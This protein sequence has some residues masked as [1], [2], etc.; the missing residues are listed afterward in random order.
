MFKKA[1]FVILA[2]LGI[3]GSGL[4]FGGQ[5][6]TK[7]INIVVCMAPNICQ[8]QCDGTND[9]VEIKNAINEAAEKGGDTVNIQDGVYNISSNLNVLA[10][11][12]TIKGD[13]ASTTILRANGNFKVLSFG[14]GSG[15][16]VYSNYKVMDLTIDMNFINS[17]QSYGLVFS[18]AQNVIVER[19]NVINA[20]ENSHNQLYFGVSSGSSTEFAK[21]LIVRDCVFDNNKGSYESV[22]FAQAR[23][24][25]FINNRIS[26]VEAFYGLLQYGSTKI[27]LIGNTFDNGANVRLDRDFSVVENNKF[28]S[29]SL[30]I[31]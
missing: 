6:T 1:L 21:N 13:G 20:G 26:N 18:S 31:T 16:T 30:V 12:I 24:I 29:S 4:L 11:N 9:D 19:V 2:V 28:L 17:N 22:L 7:D 10:D 25:Q 5:S 8:Y 15:P 14:A 23:D 27:A 3:S